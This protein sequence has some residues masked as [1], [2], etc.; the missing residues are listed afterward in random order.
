MGKKP[1]KCLKNC[2]KHNFILKPVEYFAYISRNVEVSFCPATLKHHPIFP[3]FNRDRKYYTSSFC[4][5]EDEVT[6]ILFSLSITLMIA[7][8]RGNIKNSVI[9]NSKISHKL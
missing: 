2:Q 6:F 1:Q 4:L 9:N 8:T 7:C 3:V 5:K